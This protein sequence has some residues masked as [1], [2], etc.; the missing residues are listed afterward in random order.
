MLRDRC[1]LQLKIA[2]QLQQQQ[3]HR[4]RATVS[5][6]PGV[7]PRGG[8]K[9]RIVAVRRTAD[10]SVGIRTPAHRDGIARCKASAGGFI[11]YDRVD[12]GTSAAAAAAAAARKSR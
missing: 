9:H 6:I 10:V 11:G 1:Y 2:R 8:A 3:Q 4:H 5:K 7:S 12:P